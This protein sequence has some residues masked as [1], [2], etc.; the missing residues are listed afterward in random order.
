VTRVTAAPEFSFLDDADAAAALRAVA[1]AADAAIDI[2][3]VALALS[4][5]GDPAARLEPYRAHL[6]RLADD[7]AA[8]TDT[9]PSLD[10]RIAALN[11]VLVD[12]W[13][14]RGD[15]E[16]YDNIENAD[17]RRVIDRRKGLPVS[18]GIVY[19]HAARRQGWDVVGL[20]FP[21]H[22][23]LRLSL[24]AERAILDPFGGGQVVG[25]DG[26]RRLVKAAEGEGAELSPQHY[27][28]VTDREI[29][30]RLQNNLRMRL[31]KAGDLRRTAFVTE[32]MILLAP[33][34]SALWR[35]AGLLYAELGEVEP[36]ISA[37]EHFVGA[38][39][40]GAARHEAAA[41]LQRLRARPV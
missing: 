28:A 33:A 32:T 21:G 8:A 27:E 25:A 9:A 13:G 34:E 23:L 24:G 1:G 15:A 31:F 40:S 12:T 17:L 41:L 38:S 4:A 36:A 18:L 29:L 3:E 2:A 10:A 11:A 39:A 22:F 37:L 19:L 5:Y 7:V 26:L 16:N 6:A 14:Y 30:L 35:D 20:N